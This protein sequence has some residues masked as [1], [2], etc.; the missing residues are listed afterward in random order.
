[1]KASLNL[2]LFYKLK[3]NVLCIIMELSIEG[4]NNMV[5]AMSIALSGLL[6]Q[7]QRLAASASNIANVATEGALPTAESP[8]ST[9][10]KPLSVSFEALMAGGSGAGVIAHVSENKD[11]YVPVY[12]PASVYANSDGVVAAPAVDLVAES[13]NILE[14]K[15]LYKANLAV[16]KTQNDLLGELLNIVS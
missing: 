15:S 9:V 4:G 10:Y 2:R 14:T 3:V 1:M 16:L 13:V 7:G 11:G 8:G 6:A 5:N 12:D